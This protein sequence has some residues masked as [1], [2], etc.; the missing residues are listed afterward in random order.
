M[1]H[2]QI[3]YRHIDTRPKNTVLLSAVQYTGLDSYTVRHPIWLTYQLKVYS[4][5]KYKHVSLEAFHTLTLQMNTSEHVTLYL[6]S[7]Q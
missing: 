3:Q 5:L 2:R 4:Q 6:G 7:T 1:K